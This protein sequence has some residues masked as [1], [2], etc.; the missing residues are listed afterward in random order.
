[1]TAMRQLF[2]VVLTALLIGACEGGEQPTGAPAL[3]I[4]S[5]GI[6]IFTA[7]DII[8]MDSDRPHAEA[9]A[10]SGG[11]IVAVGSL[12][13]IADELGERSHQVDSQFEN[14][15]IVPG[16]IDQHVHPLLAAL[17]MNMEIIAIE[18]WV[19][20]TGT[21]K[22]ATDHNDYIARLVAAEAEM[23]GAAETLFTWGFHH[24]F[25]GRLT[26]QDLDAISATR[27]IVVWHR[28]AHEFILN[29]P[30]MVTYGITPAFYAEF[31]ESAKAQSN[32]E[33]G[34]FWEQGW[35]AVLYKLMPVLTEPSKLRSGL[36]F[37][38]D[39]LH[40][41]G[42]TLIAEPGGLVSKE[43]QD[44]Q[45][46]VFGDVD[47]PFRS[48]FI[49]DGKTMATTQLNDLIAA[50]EAPLSWG[51]G[52]VEFLPMQ[53]KLFADGAIFSQA[54]QMIDGYTDGHEGEWMIDLDIFA[55]AFNTYWDAGYQLHIHQNGD[56]GLEMVLD[57]LEAAQRRRPREDHRTTMVHFGFSTAEQ[58]DRIAELGAIV[59]ANPYYLTALADNYSANGLGPERADEMVRLGD[60]VRAGVPLSLHSDMSMAP[61]QP[62]FLMWSAVN[63]T[64]VSGRVAGPDQRISVEEAL[65]AVTIGAAYSLR[66]EDTVGSLQPGK[67]ANL[68]ILDESPYEVDPD[69]I[70][71]IGIWGTMLEGIVYP[72]SK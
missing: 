54:M 37:V 61:S 53:V 34:H 3:N 59:S 22:A 36:E 11:R 30:A 45:N 20:P 41:A 51:S 55:E 70:K 46:A 39:Y 52:K 72:I 23:T 31:S 47:T 13:E 57:L 56:A 40:A 69:L 5:S 32:Y 12:A 2:W 50:T 67:F 10:V 24:Y 33:E 35:F 25:H 44:A 9:I 68:T 8:T 65:K 49:V 42:V 18:D 7:R 21:A 26:R 58:V 48:Y 43:L 1:M 29:T 14:Q 4:D 28:S 64:T 19:L 66:L 27:P 60:V 62:L 63:R 38:E 16:L 17:S 15:V 71:D 6:T